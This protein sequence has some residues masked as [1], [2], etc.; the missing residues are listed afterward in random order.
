MPSGRY[1]ATTHTGALS[2]LQDQSC[3]LSGARSGGDPPRMG[4][5]RERWR[6]SSN[7]IR[8]GPRKTARLE[9]KEAGSCDSRA[10]GGTGC[11][12]PGDSSLITPRLDDDV[13]SSS[14]SGV[15]GGVAEPVGFAEGDFERGVVC[16][17]KKRVRSVSDSTRSHRKE[18]ED[19]M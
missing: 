15:S 11:S 7:A 19:N 1:S 12:G 3:Q 18:I 10:G 5:R 4:P 6:Y 9:R 16:C 2:W 13:S 8:S 17:E 14:S